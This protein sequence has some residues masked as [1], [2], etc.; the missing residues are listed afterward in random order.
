[1]G[2]GFCDAK[3]RDELVAVFEEPAG[4][5]I[6]GE[7]TLTNMTEMIDVCI[8]TTASQ[9]PGVTEFFSS[10]QPAAQEKVDVDSASQEDDALEEAHET[11]VP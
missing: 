1:M 8:Q 11:D 7:K 5:W 10:W 2:G 9:R 3:M 4:R 6:G